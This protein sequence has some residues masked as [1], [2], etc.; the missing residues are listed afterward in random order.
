MNSWSLSAAADPATLGELVVELA[1]AIQ[2]LNELATVTHSADDAARVAEPLTDLA[3]VTRPLIELAAVIQSSHDRATT[4]E[5]VTR[6][7]AVA[8]PSAAPTT[9]AEPRAEVVAATSPAGLFSYTLAP[10]SFSPSLPALASTL[11]PAPGL[12]VLF[13]LISK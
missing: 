2:P 3:A 8:Q 6:P 4:A 9:I 11:L 7:A 12:S 10:P 1:A 5:S 13:P